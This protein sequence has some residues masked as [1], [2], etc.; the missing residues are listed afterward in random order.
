MSPISA[1]QRFGRM[2]VLRLSRVVY[3]KP[4]YM[5]RC[6]CGTEKE[7]RLTDLQHGRTVSRRG[8][9]M[10][11]VRA[12][13]CSG[14][15]RFAIARQLLPAA[16]MIPLLA[17]LEA[18]PDRTFTS[19]DAM[20]IMGVE[21]VRTVSSFV[22]YAHRA[23]RVYKRV[24]GTGNKRQLQ[25]RATPFPD[26]DPGRVKPSQDKS[27]QTWKEGGTQAAPKWATDPDDP[28]IGKVVEGW[29]PPVMRC[30]REGV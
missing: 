13:A 14:S 16:G 12:L 25:I 8:E 11:S 2:T 3:S 19:S 10:G 6:D 28:R 15:F 1:G 24:I 18:E 23:G 22:F 26:G 7:A 17:A 9:R 20:A 5:C 27:R 30:V 21:D 29:K 4:R